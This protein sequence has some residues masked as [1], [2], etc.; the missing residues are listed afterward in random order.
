MKILLLGLG[1]SNKAIEKYMQKHNINYVTYDDSFFRQDINLNGIDLIIKS[2]GVKNSHFLLQNNILKITDLEYFYNSCGNKKTF[3]TVTGSNGKTTTVSLLKHLI[4]DIDLGGNIGYPL[5]DFIES[6]KDII[7]EASSFMLEYIRN[8]HSKYIVLLNIHKTHLDHHLTFTNYIKSKINILKNVTEDDYIIYN[9]DDTIIKRIVNLYPGI[10]IPFSMHNMNGV[11][12]DEVYI[13]YQG[14]PVFLK[15]NIKLLGNHNV[16]N[17]M[18]AIAVVLNYR[19][20]LERISSFYGVKYRLEFIGNF[21]GIDI[22]NDS[23][24]TNFLATSEALRALKSKKVLLIC[25]GMRRNDEYS[26]LEDVENVQKIY[27]YGENRFDFLKH[28]NSL[29]KECFLYSH[30]EEVIANLSLEVIDTILF[31]PGSVSYDQFS[32]YIA[33]GEKFNDLIKKKMNVLKA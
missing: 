22:Y 7:I 20:N 13:Y 17:I 26:L 21:N 27:L 2:S 23:K 8:F 25:G 11:Y 18:A 9:D 28:F 19:G 24:S 32:D 1:I 30:L 4:D 6:S 31:S 14:K 5:F 12:C 33:R 10:K 29:R 16:M 3:I 15:K